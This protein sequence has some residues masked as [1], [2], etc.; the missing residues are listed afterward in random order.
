MA[1][2]RMKQESKQRTL[3]AA[4]PLS[5]IA[6]QKLICGKVLASARSQEHMLAHRWVTVVF[7]NQYH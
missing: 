5:M 4:S 3:T 1:T 6:S 7:C 2:R